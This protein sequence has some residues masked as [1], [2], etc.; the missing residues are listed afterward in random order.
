MTYPARR[1]CLVLLRHALHD[2]RYASEA[3][4][5]FMV[6]VHDENDVH[7]LEDSISTD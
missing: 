7:C 2:D 6:I 3:P 4:V 1:Q 5:L